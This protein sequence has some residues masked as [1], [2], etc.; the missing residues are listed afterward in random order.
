MEL[1]G[2]RMS[3]LAEPGQVGD[4]SSLRGRPVH[5]VAG[6]G[7][8]QRFFDRLARHGLRVTRHPFPDHYAYRP[9][10]LDFGDDAPVLMTEKDAVKCSEFARAHW[11]ALTAEVRL[12]SGLDDLVIA[13]LQRQ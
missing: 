13:R 7:N 5:A 9:A 6:I 3:N 12:E 4:L 11:W 8:P 1:A 2:T 10:D